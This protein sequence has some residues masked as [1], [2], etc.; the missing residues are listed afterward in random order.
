MNV[1]FAAALELQS[2][3]FENSWKYC[4]IGA[5]AVARWGKPDFPTNTRPS[6]ERPLTNSTR[7]AY[8]ERRRR[9]T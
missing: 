1:V 5:I 3:V 8:C 9:K 2:F 7:D 6:D 4:I